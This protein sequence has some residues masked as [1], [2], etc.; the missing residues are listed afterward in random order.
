VPTW[1][2]NAWAE[3]Q[4]FQD[5]YLRGDNALAQAAM[6]RAR[7]ALASTGKASLLARAELFR[8][9]VRAA[10]L[11]FDHCAAYQPYAL[12]AQAAELAYAAYLTAA[13]PALDVAQLPTP[14]QALAQQLKTQSDAWPQGERLAD[15]SEPLARLVAAAVLFQSGKLSAQDVALAVQTASDQGWRR[16][17]LAWLSVQQQ[18]ALAAG[19]DA[20]A[21]ALQQRMDLIL[22]DA[23]APP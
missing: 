6:A 1:Q 22:S 3:L 23:Q 4:N 11:A 14:H 20:Q 12:A 16:P 7:Q 17:L 9:A 8:C 2:L 10:S 19:L 21:Q 15:F 5:A 18:R 13:W